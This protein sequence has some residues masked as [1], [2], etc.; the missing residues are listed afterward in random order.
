MSITLQQM[1]SI[2]ADLQRRVHALEHAPTADSFAL[3]NTTVI[4]EYGETVEHITVEQ[5]EFND[6]ERIYIANNELIL[7]N[8]ATKRKRKLSLSEGQLLTEAEK[9]YWEDGKSGRHELGAGGG[10]GLKLGEYKEPPNAP[11]AGAVLME[12]GVVKEE[13]DFLVSAT[14]DTFVTLL[15]TFSV[16][17]SVTNNGAHTE[18]M[19]I[20]ETAFAWLADA[21]LPEELDTSPGTVQAIKSSVIVPKGAKIKAQANAAKTG[22]KPNLSIK[23]IAQLTLD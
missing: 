2:A 12:N 23:A 7:E 21:I 5:L 9:L 13:L 14:N 19:L 22:G 8:K 16:D 20:V 3:P 6:G 17:K 11:P 10:G 1:E 18:G 4:N 15:W